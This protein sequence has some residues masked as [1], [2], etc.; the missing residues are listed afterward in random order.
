V[1]HVDSSGAKTI[2]VDPA[3]GDVDFAPSL[4]LRTS[5]SVFG[6]RKTSGEMK[7][8][9]TIGED[10]P[11]PA[12]WERQREK[13]R[14]EREAAEKKQW[15]ESDTARTREITSKAVTALFLVLL[16]WFRVSRESPSSPKEE[17]WLSGWWLMVD[18]R[19]PE[20]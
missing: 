18:G 17:M 9:G 3:T 12:E 14:L 19:C 20:V 4:S 15:E 13:E 8:L 11:D 7:T 16:K 2:I 5:W 1:R 10:P 6:K